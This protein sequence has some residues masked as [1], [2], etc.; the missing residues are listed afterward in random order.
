ML[1]VPLRL[2]RILIRIL[3]D[4]C[5]SFLFRARFSR[6][7]QINRDEHEGEFHGA[8]EERERTER[9]DLRQDRFDVAELSS[10][11]GEAQLDSVVPGRSRCGNRD[12]FANTGMRTHTDG[13]YPV[14]ITAGRFPRLRYAKNSKP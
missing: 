3:R 4:L 2:C 14:E 5:N 9:E 8:N 7:R 13:R 1:S 11:R 12:G 10:A 6:R